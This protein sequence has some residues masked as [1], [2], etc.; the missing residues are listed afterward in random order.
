V[1]GRFRNV[2]EGDWKL[3]W[4]PGQS[5]ELEYELYRLSDDPTESQDLY[6]SHPDEAE[7][8]KQQLAGWLRALDDRSVEP[9]ARD[10]VLLRRLGYVE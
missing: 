6:A 2:I 5:P 8:L 10:L 7:H 1:S 9:D 4:T 3:I